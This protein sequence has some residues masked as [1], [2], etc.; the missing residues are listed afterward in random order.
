MSKA[1]LVKG[2]R[3]IDPASGHDA[4]AD[5]V[6]V[7]G[8]FAGVG[9][10]SERDVHK[11]F[12][13]VIEVQTLDAG[14]LVVAPGLVD[15][16]AHM[17]EPGHDSEESI[18]HGAEVA[19]RGGFTTVACLP[20]TE[21]ALDNVAAALF[22]KRQS[23]KAGFAEVH[24]I[25]ALTKNREGKEL[26]EIGQL[27]EAGAVAFGDEQR[28]TDEPG[29]LLRGMRYAAMFDRVVIEYAQDPGLASGAMNAGYEAT[30]AGLPG[31]PSVSEELAIARACMFAREAGCHYHAALLS[32][33]NAVRAVKRAQKL[34]VSV[35][36]E[37]CAHH[38][39]FTDDV[40]RRAYDTHYKVFPPFRR[41]EDIA[42]LKRGLREN[43]ISC[44]TSGHRPVP[45]QE[46]ELEFGRAPF[47]AVGLETTLGAT[48]THI[49]NTGELS[50]SAALAKLTLNPARVLRL[51]DRKGAIA[52]GLDGDLCVFDPAH[53]WAVTPEAL[54][55]HSKNSPFIGTKLQGRA[56]F[57]VT[58][59]RVF[60]LA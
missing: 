43:V 20:D 60:D 59:G 55:S 47:G 26:T 17:G 25:C 44:I 4:V 14:N 13:H 3:V 18:A 46:K 11:Q 40:V 38:L 21:P 24:P 54:S 15:M 32:T 52:E 12:S 34:G 7:G 57:V 50:L 16:R 10:F 6:V 58:R 5:V 1:I 2:G 42:W 23:E 36:S 22:V 29:G 30:L 33:R 45:P 56:K 35:T 53:E 51:H 19:V 48:I 37:V 8:K 41:S 27:I 9:Q 39:A 31:I 49:V 28:A